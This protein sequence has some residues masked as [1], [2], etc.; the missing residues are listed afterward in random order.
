MPKEVVLVLW[1]WKR[2]V[3]GSFAFSKRTFLLL[4]QVLFL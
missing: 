4:G 3:V 1:Y 2:R